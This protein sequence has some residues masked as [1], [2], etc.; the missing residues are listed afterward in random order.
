MKFT[1]VYT[2]DKEIGQPDD[3]LIHLVPPWFAPPSNVVGRRG[4]LLCESMEIGDIRVGLDAGQPRHF[5]RY[6]DK[7]ATC[8]ACLARIV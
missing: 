1:S 8:L 2:E 4:T 3:G 7:A 6:S 5:V